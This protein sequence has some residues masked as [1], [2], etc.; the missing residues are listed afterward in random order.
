MDISFILEDL[1]DAQRTA[2]T[3]DSTHALVLAGAGSGKTR[4]LVHR[5]AYLMRVMGVSPY[6]ILAVTFT[7]K[8]ANEMRGR[9]EALVGHE[10][11]GLSMGTFHGIAYRLLRQH[12]QE[13][14]LPQAFQILDSDDQKR[15]IK[16]LLKSMELDESQWPHRQVQAFINGEKEEGRRPEHIDIGFNPFV[17]KMVEIYRAYEL[18]CQRSGLVDFA[19]LLLRAHELWLNHPDILSHYQARYQHILVDEFQ[20]TNRLQY[21]WLRVLAGEHS[22]LFVVGDD[23]QSIYGWRGAR[24]ENIQQFESELAPVQT[25][26][27]EQNYR[28]TGTILNAA[29]ALIAHNTSRMGKELWSAGEDGA[30]IRVYEAFNEVDEARYVCSQ[31][32]AWCEQ[33]GERSDIAVLYRSNAQSR[34]MEQAL[35]QANIP[36]RV[37]GGLRFYDRAEIKDVLSYLRLLVNRDDDAAFERVYNHPPRGIGQKTADTIRNIAKQ[38]DIPLWQ[39]AQKVVEQGMAARAKT[40]VQGFLS[41]IDALAE[42]VKNLPLEEQMMKVIMRSGLQAHFEKDC[43]E[44]GKG[45]LENIDELINA[46]SVFKPSEIQMRVLDVPPEAQNRHDADV[47][48]VPSDEG[49]TVD[50]LLADFLAQAALEAGEQQADDWESSVQ[51]MTLHA[52]KGLEFPLVFLIGMEEGLFPSQRSLE[53]PERLEE[54]RRLAYVGITRAETQ[55][56]IT[57]ANRRRM[58]GTEFYPKPSRFIKELPEHCLDFVRLSGASVPTLESVSE[59][60][61]QRSNGLCAGDW[62]SH[63]KFGE[64]VVVSMEGEGEYARVNVQ[65]SQVGAKWLVMAYA[66]LEKKG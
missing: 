6:N 28:S 9:I 5:M 41:L 39:A 55:L 53:A 43:S 66:N 24:V 45:R 32:E 21:A 29:N 3:L 56:I 61:L 52:A 4:V 44:Q 14:G 18:Q 60:V 58:H 16:R 47:Y 30:P 34:V 11:T 20:D 65:F 10:A 48:A 15:V 59:S 62:V 38:Q 51:L 25:V 12:Y 49:K 31:M 46:A 13:A 33:G 37:Y 22:K 19:E 27:L 36:Y 50:S 40:A 63:P 2:V 57:F 42:E 35:M 26:R 54:E 17:A 8:A 64:G 23:D 7:N 1:N